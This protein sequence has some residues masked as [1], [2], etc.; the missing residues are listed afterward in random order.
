MIRLSRFASFAVI[1]ALWIPAM[2]AVAWGAALAPRLAPG[3][4]LAI[5]HADVI[6]TCGE[7][8][9]WF[10]LFSLPAAIFLARRTPRFFI[11]A[12]SLTIPFSLIVPAAAAILLMPIYFYGLGIAVV[13]DITWNAGPFLWALLTALFLAHRELPLSPISR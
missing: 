12:L 4:S 3:S 1:L 10:A 13:A 2:L 7:Y 9:S 8:G 5:K 11:T 6:A